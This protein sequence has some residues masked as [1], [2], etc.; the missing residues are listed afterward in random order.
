MQGIAGRSLVAV[1]RLSISLVRR[2]KYLLLRTVRAE[3]AASERAALARDLHDNLI[4]SLIS[5]EMKLA[6]LVRHAG[7][8]DRKLAEDLE[9]IREYLRQEILGVRRLMRQLKGLTFDAREAI[10][11]L[12]CVAMEFQNESGITTLFNAVPEALNLPPPACG[13]MVYILREALVN[14]G[15][16][17]GADEIRIQLDENETHCIMEI[18]DNGEGFDFQGRL[19][20]AQLDAQG[21][22]P[23]L[24]K[25]RIRGLNGD[26][27]IESFPGK[28]ACLQIYIPK[29]HGSE[30][31]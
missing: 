13:E 27:T 30:K 24:I 11:A 3:A 17:S 26:L 6:V 5:I 28:S 12:R 10:E 31:E 16:H 15:K 4:Q 23:W 1:W 14:A 19:S 8:Q 9:T 18:C 2:S 7:R 21:K 22:G 20:L 29:R 25:E